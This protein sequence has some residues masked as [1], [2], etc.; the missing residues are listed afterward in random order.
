M[1]TPGIDSP[2]SM[3]L[4][5]ILLDNPSV[6]T[7]KWKQKWVFPSFQASNS[8]SAI[9]MPKSNRLYKISSAAQHSYIMVMILSRLSRHHIVQSRQLKHVHHH[10]LAHYLGLNPQVSD[11]TGNALLLEIPSDTAPA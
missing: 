3:R 9:I 10:Y 7:T 6:G 8:C 5:M 11:P 1:P 4:T 2:L